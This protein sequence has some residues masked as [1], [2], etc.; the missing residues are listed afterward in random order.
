M[1]KKH[2]GPLA[3]ISIETLVGS[4]KTTPPSTIKKVLFFTKKSTEFPDFSKIASD[5]LTIL[6]FEIR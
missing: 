1:D 2:P 3:E 5:A 4:V 6:F